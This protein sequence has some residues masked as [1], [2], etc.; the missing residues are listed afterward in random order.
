MLHVAT[1]VERVPSTPAL[2][3]KCCLSSVCSCCRQT[4]KEKEKKREREG[5]TSPFQS[6]I[7]LSLFLFHS[8]HPST[9]YPKKIHPSLF[10]QQKEIHKSTFLSFHFI[11]LR[12]S[13][14]LQ[15]QFSFYNFTPLSH[16]P[17]QFLFSA[18]PVLDFNSLTII[19]T[20][21]IQFN[22]NFFPV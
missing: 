9:F 17:S 19:S 5:L 21:Q 14:S 7:S 20:I 4:Q 16:F 2:P 13:T 12:T 6:T 10:R 1:H 3:K 15:I 22:F 11:H 8:N 18:F